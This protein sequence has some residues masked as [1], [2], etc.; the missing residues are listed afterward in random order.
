MAQARWLECDLA[1]GERHRFGVAAIT[2]LGA[3]T[4]HFV[5]G[6]KAFDTHT[7]CPHNAGKIDPQNMRHGYFR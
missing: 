2:A 7:D 1:G 5:L 6:R 4:E 3:D